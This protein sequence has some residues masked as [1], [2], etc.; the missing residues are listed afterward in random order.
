[1]GG[2]VVPQKKTPFFLGTK[3]GPNYCPPFCGKNIKSESLRCEKKRYLWERIWS[4]NDVRSSRGRSSTE[5]IGASQY[6]V[7]MVETNGVGQL[8]KEGIEYTRGV[9]KTA[10]QGRK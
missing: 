8:L 10:G 3:E 5:Q 9:Y 1:V 7:V 4:N 6:H 2:L